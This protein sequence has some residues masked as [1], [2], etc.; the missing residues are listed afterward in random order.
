MVN[1]VVNNQT[2]TKNT[3]MMFVFFQCQ[4][5]IVMNFLSLEFLGINLVHVIRVCF[6][7]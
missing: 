7:K 6:R 3:N 4:A 5:F 2:T 1:E